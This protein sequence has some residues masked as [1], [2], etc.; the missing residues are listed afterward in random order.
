MEQKLLLGLV[1]DELELR[2]KRKIR[3]ELVEEL[4][5]VQVHPTDPTKTT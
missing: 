1:W 4:V 3:G 5:L 2:Y